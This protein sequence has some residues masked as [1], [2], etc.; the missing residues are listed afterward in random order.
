[1]QANVTECFLTNNPE[2]ILYYND[3]F[4]FQYITTVPLKINFHFLIICVI[5]KILALLKYHLNYLK[6][7]ILECFFKNY[8]RFLIVWIKITTFFKR[9]ASIIL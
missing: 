2:E 6:D 9:R 5:D 1:M 3:S 7:N 4:H 8:N